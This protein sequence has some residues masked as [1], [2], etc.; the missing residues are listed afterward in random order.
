MH[1]AVSCLQCFRNLHW[2]PWGL[3]P[4]AGLPGSTA[5]APRLAG[6]TRAA[7]VLCLSINTF[8]RTWSTSMSYKQVD[9]DSVLPSGSRSCRANRQSLWTVLQFSCRVGILVTKD[10]LI[11]DPTHGRAGEG[12]EVQGGTRQM[13]Q[14]E[15]EKTKPMSS[16]N[17]SVPTYFSL[18]LC[19]LFWMTVHFMLHK[20]A[21]NRSYFK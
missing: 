5:V 13:Q 2:A 1:S 8:R 3:C 15:L 9:V 21:Q 14:R 12:T 17:S 19:H 11:W 20:G 7:A 4:G 6:R 18:C 16:T 10:G